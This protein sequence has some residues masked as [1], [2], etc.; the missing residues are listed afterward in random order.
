M[1][2]TKNSLFLSQTS[3]IEELLGTFK[4]HDWIKNSVPIKVTSPLDT[5]G[6]KMENKRLYQSM[7]GSLLYVNLVSTPDTSFGFNSLGSSASVS[8]LENY[9]VM[10]KV[11]KYLGKSK[12]RGIRLDRKP[13]IDLKFFVDSALETGRSFTFDN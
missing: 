4:L 3:Y 6:T 13:Q 12:L 5:E 8:T 10:C 11:I 1:K 9:K 2:R 7:I